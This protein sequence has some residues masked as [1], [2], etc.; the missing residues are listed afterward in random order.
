MNEEDA[1][2]YSHDLDSAAFAVLAEL[3]DEDGIRFRSLE[4]YELLRQKAQEHRVFIRK[5]HQL[6]TDLRG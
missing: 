4:Y 3:D 6:V 1:I 2:E 5:L